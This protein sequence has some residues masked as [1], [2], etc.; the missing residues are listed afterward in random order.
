MNNNNKNKQA[1]L[2]C[3][4]NFLQKI[5]CCFGKKQKQQTQPLITNEKYQ[6]PFAFHGLQNSL[7]P[8]KVTLH[9]FLLKK[10]GQKIKSISKDVHSIFIDRSSLNPAQLKELMPYIFPY[11]HE[12]IITH[13]QSISVLPFCVT[14]YLAKRITQFTKNLIVDAITG[15]GTLSIEIAQSN[16]AQV[17]SYSIDENDN[18]KYN[19]QQFH[20]YSTQVQNIYLTS[21]FERQEK[22]DAIIIQYQFLNSFL[23]DSNLKNYLQKALEL[24]ENIVIVLPSKIQTNDLCAFLSPFSHNHNHIFRQIE[25]QKI[26]VGGLPLCQIVY[27]GFIQ[28][29]ELLNEQLKNCYLKELLADQPNLEDQQVQ[30]FKNLLN[31]VITQI[32]MQKTM[33]LIEKTLETKT[34]L[35]FAI[36]LFLQQIAQLNIVSLENIANQMEC[37]LMDQTPTLN[38]PLLYNSQSS[39]SKKQ[40]SL[41]IS[42]DLSKTSQQQSKVRVF[43]FQ[44]KTFE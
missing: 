39:L 37:S 32:G 20:Y 4:Q 5:N 22:A 1:K 16:A 29:E 7:S 9:N 12:L 40:S 44:N 18:A 34:Q 24:S 33:L 25:I 2:S 21:F 31:T 36:N 23:L 42:S 19:I 35:D 43:S 27:I 30:N 6:S 3:C 26:N 11:M 41:R 14:Q 10:S 15:P 8:A 17:D 13:E 38:H 28:D